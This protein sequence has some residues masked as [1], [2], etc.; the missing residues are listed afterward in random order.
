MFIER[1]ASPQK[2]TPLKIRKNNES[3]WEVNKKNAS[4]DVVDPFNPDTPRQTAYHL[5]H[6]RYKKSF[7]ASVQRCQE[8]RI[9]F[10]DMDWVAVKTTALQEYTNKEGRR[11]KSVGGNIYLHYLTKCIHEYD[12]NFSFSSARVSRDIQS[13]LRENELEKLKEKG[14]I[15]E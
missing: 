10:T 6:K 7:P 15:T 13:V 12:Q 8:C 5:V 9:C 11:V 14:C 4:G 1:V 3:S 2:V